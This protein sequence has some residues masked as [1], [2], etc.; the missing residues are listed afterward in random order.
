MFFRPIGGGII[1]AHQSAFGRAAADRRSSA[2]LG[3]ASLK[4]RLHPAVNLPYPRSSALLGAAS[5]KRERI[6]ELDRLARSSS[7]LLGAASLKLEHR[8]PIMPRRP[9]SSSALLGAASLKRDNLP[10]A[11]YAIAKVLPPYWGRHH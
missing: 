2:L 3:A 10:L 7:A 11:V 1:E 6:G 5:L 9:V 8:P 4:Q